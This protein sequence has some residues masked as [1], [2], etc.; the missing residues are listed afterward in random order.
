MPLAILVDIPEHCVQ[1]QNF[2]QW[3]VF[4]SAGSQDASRLASLSALYGVS[5]VP[6]THLN[7]T[8]RSQRS[9][10]TQVLQALHLNIYNYV[11]KI[12]PLHYDNFKMDRDFS[13]DITSPLY[14]C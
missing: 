1:K 12:L 6:I 14:L 9:Q 8:Q 3:R 10:I 11:I 13:R 7:I 2:V 4:E 5:K